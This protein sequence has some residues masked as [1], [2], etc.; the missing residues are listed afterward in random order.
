MIRPLRSRHRLT[1][2]LLAIIVPILFAL[3]LWARQSVPTDDSAISPV[4]PARATDATP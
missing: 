1:V 2:T 4:P 3:G